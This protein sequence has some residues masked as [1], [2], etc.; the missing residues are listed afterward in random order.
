MTTPID[1]Y[2]DTSSSRLRDAALAPTTHASYTKNLNKFLIFTRLSLPELMLLSPTIIDQRM[3]EYID[4][5]FSQR[6]SYEY[7][8]QAVFG[9]IYRHPPIKLY[10]GESR[11]RLRG[12]KRLKTGKSHPPITW[13][14]VCVFSATMAKWGRHA[15]AVATLVAFDCFLRV[16]EMTRIQYRDVAM[17]NDPRMGG[18]HAQMVLRLALT[19][20]GINQS[21]SIENSIVRD[22]LQGYLLAYPF[23]DKDRIFPFSPSSFRQTIR[24]VS[25]SLGLSHIPFVPHSFRH[26]GATHYFFKGSS[27][28]DIMF[29]GRWVALESTRRYITTARALLIMNTIPSHLHDIGRTLGPK[30]LD[31]LLT[32]MESVP[33]AR[34]RHW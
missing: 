34:V 26:G 13:E 18:I 19:K 31:V 11:M 23:M 9:L 24:E 6:G 33:V 15:E 17:P 10:L 25:D 5:L 21:V 28:E 8:C 1:F 16:G 14:L 7:A 4:D 29:R 2:Y 27:I 30:M 20:T 32:L 12:W 3:A 22:A